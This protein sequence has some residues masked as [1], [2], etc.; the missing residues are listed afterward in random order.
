MSSVNRILKLAQIRTDG[1]TQPRTEL[2]ESAVADY[3]ESI[4]EGAKFPPVTV[5][6]DGA[7]YW[8]ADGFHRFFAHKKIGALDINAEVHQGTKRDAI[9]HSVGAN[10]SHGL[11]R[12][13]EDKRKAVLTL[14]EDPEW[15]QWSNR[16]IARR[17]CVSDKTVASVRESLTAEIRS[18]EPDQR[19][20]TTKHGTEAVMSTANIGK[21]KERA[22]KQPETSLPDDS[23]LSSA[24]DGDDD[25]HLGDESLA[26]IVDELQKENEHLYVRIKAL[27]ADDTGAQLEREIR[28]RQG[29]E[30]R[31]AQE[32]DRANRLDSELRG[33]G[34]WMAELRKLLRVDGGRREITAVIRS[35]IQETQ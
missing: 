15:A 17:C 31:L 14:L 3:A 12:T 20:Y 19:T 23:S 10:A 18:E 8:L 5:F 28:I 11:R 26:D 29:I 34:K 24:Q 1:G 7:L 16:E 27:T 2:N 25:N 9:L 13:N 21:K 6:Y 35:L 22:P 32:M 4:T 30:A 33:Y